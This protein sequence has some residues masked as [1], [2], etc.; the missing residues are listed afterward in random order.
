MAIDNLDRIDII[1]T[2]KTSGEVVL[3]ITDHYDWC[4]EP[5]HI[6]AL[7]R[8]LSMYLAAVE[9]GELFRVYPD[10]RGRAVRFDVGALHRPTDSGMKFLGHIAA[11]LAETN[12]ELCLLVSPAPGSGH[13]PEEIRIE[14][15]A[16]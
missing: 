11:A 14:P 7:R 3:T 16:G 1:G 4:D 12:I 5:A 13:P 10:A 15:L 9:N 2:D 6:D 8:K